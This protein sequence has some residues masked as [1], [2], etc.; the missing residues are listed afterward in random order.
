MTV[1]S[2]KFTIFIKLLLKSLSYDT[3]ASSH[4]SL[5]SDDLAMSK[6]I[7]N[8][9]KYHFVISLATPVRFERTT[10]CLEGSCSIQLSYGAIAY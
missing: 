3:L 9:N 8:I 10:Y 6:I 7:R 2:L 1:L 4:T 5:K